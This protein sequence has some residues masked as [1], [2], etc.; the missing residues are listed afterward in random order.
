MIVIT[1]IILVHIL[2][3]RGQ[4][5][6]LSWP[7]AFSFS[8]SDY[9]LSSHGVRESSYHICFCC[10][11]AL[12]WSLFRLR[13]CH[14][15]KHLVHSV[16]YSFFCMRGRHSPYSNCCSMPLVITSII[17][18]DCDVMSVPSLTRCPHTELLLWHHSDVSSNYQTLV[19]ALGMKRFS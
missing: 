10:Q 4:V 2:F 13:I 3:T 17:K 19:R 16:V 15:G 14:T 6:P 18:V 8:D 1:Y 12:H 7:S 5:N 9:I 11:S